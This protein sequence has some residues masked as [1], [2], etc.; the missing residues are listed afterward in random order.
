MRQ[1]EETKETQ[2]TNDGSDNSSKDRCFFYTRGR[3]I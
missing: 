3:F 1:Q 2:V